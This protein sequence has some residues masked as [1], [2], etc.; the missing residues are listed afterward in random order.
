MRRVSL[1][2]LVHLPTY[3]PMYTLVYTSQDPM[4][5]LVYT[6]QDHR[7]LITRVYSLSGP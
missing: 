5:T 2:L 7:V 3:T 1:S 4:Y 6:S